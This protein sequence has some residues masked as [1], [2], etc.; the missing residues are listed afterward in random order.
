MGLTKVN[1]VCRKKIL[2]D[3]RERYKQGTL[4]SL[5]K[6]D[7]PFTKIP[8]GTE[9]TVLFVDDAGTIH[10]NWSNGSSLGV[11]YNVDI[12]EIKSAE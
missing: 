1:S 7:D 8:E 10:V 2:K 6:M 11:V 12:V 9:G 4:I 5:I 3:L